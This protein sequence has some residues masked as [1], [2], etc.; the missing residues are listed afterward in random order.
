M[1]QLAMKLT[2]QD[3]TNI[4]ELNL[5]VPLAD[6][7]PPLEPDP[8]EPETAEPLPEAADPVPER[9]STCRSRSRRSLELDK[10]SLLEE[11]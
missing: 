11:S 3:I 1:S 8:M 4:T 5:L 9:E 10:A 2:K 6:V 7:L